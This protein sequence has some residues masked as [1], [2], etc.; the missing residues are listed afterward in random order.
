MADIPQKRKGGFTPPTAPA[1][2]KDAIFKATE[3]VVAWKG[4]CV[5]KDCD[6]NA[7]V[8][9]DEKIGLCS[10]HYSDYLSNDKKIRR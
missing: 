4:L 5:W 3:P 10:F 8:Q 1:S 2:P 9:I 7:T 6:K